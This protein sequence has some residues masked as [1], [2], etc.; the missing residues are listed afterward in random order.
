MKVDLQRASLGVAWPWR[1]LKTLY[2]DG[3]EVSFKL[4][5]F[6]ASAVVIKQD[7]I[8]TLANHVVLA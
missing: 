4:L 8:D 6:S 7:A 5:Y 2:G 1:R 3:P